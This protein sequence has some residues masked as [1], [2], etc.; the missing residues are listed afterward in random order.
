MGEML[1]KRDKDNPHVPLIVKGTPWSHFVI[2]LASGT[3]VGRGGD[4][5]VSLLAFYFDDPSS[6][7][8]TLTA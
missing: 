5:V 7:P 6:N 3:Y 1:D 8:A 2:R 4:R